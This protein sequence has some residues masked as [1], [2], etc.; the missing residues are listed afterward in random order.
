MEA[1]PTAVARTI[2]RPRTSSG[3]H[4]DL[5]LSRSSGRRRGDIV[6]VDP[7]DRRRRA[8]TALL[9]LVVEQAV[10]RSR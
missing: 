6:T 9:D 3:P 4:P 1:N 10:R 2:S 8:R 5:V 7:E